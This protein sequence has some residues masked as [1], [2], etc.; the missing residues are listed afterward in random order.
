MSRDGQSQLIF[1]LDVPDLEQAGAWVA[2]LAP[3]VGLF[4]V[5]LELFSAAGPDAVRAVQQRGAA[6]VFLDLK[7]HDIPSTVGRAARAARGLGV[8]MLTVHAQGGKATLEAAVRGAGPEV[9]VLAITRLTSQQAGDEEV[10]EAAKL[11][12]A[13]GCGGVV[14]AGTEAP[15]VRRAVGTELRIVC[16]GIRAADTERADQVRVVTPYQAILSGADYLVVGRPIR[17]AADP[18][19]AAQ[20]ISAEITRARAG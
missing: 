6:G 8:R 18:V 20:A 7:L 13:A 11:A 10:V 16:P 19:Q 5:G 15:A 17:D 4:K 12:E 3:H 1:A 2:R 14:C 9:C